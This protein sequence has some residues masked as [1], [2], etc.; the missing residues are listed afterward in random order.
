MTAPAVLVVID[1]NTAL[2]RAPRSTPCSN[3]VPRSAS[4]SPGSPAT[5]AILPRPCGAVV[6]LTAKGQLGTRGRPLEHTGAIDRRDHRRVGGRASRDRLGHVCSR[7]SS[8]RAGGRHRRRA[9]RL[10]VPARRDRCRR[11][12]RA[13]KRS[14]NTGARVAA[15]RTG[16]DQHRGLAS[17]S[18]CAR[19]PAR[20]HRRHHRVPA[21]ASSCRRGSRR[22]RSRTR[23][24]T[25][26]FLLVDYKGGSR[27]PGLRVAARTA[28]G[29]VTNLDD[30]LV[31]RALVVAEGRAGA[32]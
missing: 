18:T 30:H 17:P 13:R 24:R 25:V 12:H 32:P 28:S 22:S 20:A 1:G 11:P 4:T 7:L 23:P 8:T 10:G 26:N 5:S 19:R 27:L 16:R 9:A 2:D 29:M 15:A 14:S 31:H 6:E 21:R 3:R